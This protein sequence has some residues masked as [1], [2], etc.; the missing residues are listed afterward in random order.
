[1]RKLKVIAG[2]RTYGHTV[3]ESDNLEAYTPCS[4]EKCANCQAFHKAV[5]E[6]VDTIIGSEPEMRYVNPQK[7]EFFEKE[8][9]FLLS[10]ERYPKTPRPLSTLS[11]PK[12]PRPLRWQTPIDRD[13]ISPSEPIIIPKG[14]NLRVCAEC[15]KDEDVSI[16]GFSYTRCSYCEGELKWKK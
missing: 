12:N 6:Y 5:R 1:M 3:Y 16:P 11:T 4:D 7:I 15:G 9:R 13:F 2:C 10:Q 14:K 8:A